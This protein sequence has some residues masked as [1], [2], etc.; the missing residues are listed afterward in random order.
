MQAPG[1]IRF[2]KTTLYGLILCCLVFAGV[3]W[4]IFSW[5]TTPLPLSQVTI[6]KIAPGIPVAEFARTLRDANVIDNE[7]WFLYWV[8]AQRIY[9]HIQAGTYRFGDPISPAQLL[10]TFIKGPSAQQIMVSLTVPEGYSLKQIVAKLVDLGIGTNEEL[11]QLAL[12]PAFISSLGLQAPS[13]EGFLYPATYYFYEEHPTPQEVFTEMVSEFNRRIPAGYREQLA[14]F[15]I[16]F[17]EAVI[18]ASMIEKETDLPEERPLISEVI[19]RRLRANIPLAIDAA[20]IYG[21]EDYHGN[22]RTVHL[23]NREN[24]YNTRIHRGLPPTPIASP[25]RASLAAVVSPSNFGYLYYVLLPG[26]EGR[27]HFAKTLKEHNHYVQ[28]LIKA[29]SVQGNK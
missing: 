4:R 2:L 5:S 23:R 22:L 11:M 20:V 29:R 14:A 27:H 16:S 18:I 19:W 13:L 28:K 7:L 15:E 1:M 3:L 9:Q 21:S 17:Y 12:D 26:G 8:K 24:L 6:I 25:T 10:E